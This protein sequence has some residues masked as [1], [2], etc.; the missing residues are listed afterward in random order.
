MSFGEITIIL[1]NVELTLRIPKYG[2][3][4]NKNFI[5]DQII[6]IIY[7]GF[8]LDF[9]LLRTVIQI[10]KFLCQLYLLLMIVPVCG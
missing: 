7:D 3:L 4:L 2:E 1:H 6:Q 5:Q 9:P 10:L 8:G